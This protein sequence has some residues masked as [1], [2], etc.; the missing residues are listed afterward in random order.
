MSESHKAVTSSELLAYLSGLLPTYMLPSEVT[1][2]DQMPH[3]QRGK[4]DFEYL[5]EILVGGAEDPSHA[6]ASD[7]QRH[8]E[9]VE[10]Q[11]AA[12]WATVLGVAPATNDQNFFDAGGQSFLVVELHALLEECFVVSLSPIDIFRYPSVRLLAEHIER[13]LVIRE[14]PGSSQANEREQP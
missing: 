12:I 6:G 11:V 13:L 2:I 9:S 4:I 10:E 8:T 1:I 14:I 5:R 3:G 7:A